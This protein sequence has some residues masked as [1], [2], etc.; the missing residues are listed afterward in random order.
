MSEFIKR[1]SAKLGALAATSWPDNRIQIGRM[2]VLGELLNFEKTV[3]NELETAAEAAKQ[4]A[5]LEEMDVEF[6]YE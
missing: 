5:E 2:H 3:I 4:N 1:W 6:E